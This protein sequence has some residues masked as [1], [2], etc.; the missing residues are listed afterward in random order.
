MKILLNCVIDFFPFKYAKKKQQI[1][2]AKNLKW[3]NARSAARI[4]T[5]K[6]RLIA[7]FKPHTTIL[8]TEQQS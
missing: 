6:V 8:A 4:H 5:S 1:S 3:L 2:I 7:L